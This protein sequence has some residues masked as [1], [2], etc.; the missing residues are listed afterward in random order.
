MDSKKIERKH[1]NQPVSSI[2]FDT[3]TWIILSAVTLYY[4]DIVNALKVDH[5]ISG[6]FLHL[7]V[8]SSIIAFSIGLYFIVWVSMVKGVHSDDWETYV[9]FGI[10]IA[11]GSGVSAGICWTIALWGV[12]GI[13]SPIIVF[14]LFMGFVMTVSIIPSWS[15]EKPTPK[16]TQ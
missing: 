8:I 10:P 9:P 13:K 12:Y 16:K 2:G 3:I 15:E 1:E 7:A 4:T 6:Y 14:I 11:T 5:R